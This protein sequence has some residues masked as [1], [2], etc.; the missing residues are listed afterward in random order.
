MF[1]ALTDPVAG[2]LGLSALVACVP[3]LTFFVM[4]IGVKAKA[5]I[6]AAVALVAALIVAVV[7]F[8]MPIGYALISATQGAAF[9]AFPIVYIILL[10]V[11]FYEVTVR[12]GRSEDLRRFFDKV[13]GGDIRIQ[14][15]LIAFSFGGL[16]EALAG[17]GAPIAITATMILALGVKPKRAA[18]A[19]MLANTAPVAYGAVAT[20][21]TTAGNMV[22]GGDASVASAT[23]QHVAAIVGYQAPLFALSV[24]LLLVI[25]LD[26]KRGARECW[27]PAMVVGGSFAITQWWCSNHFAYE[28]TDVV[29]ALVSMA[30][31]VAFM[32]FWKPRGVE[33]VRKDF[34]LPP[35][36]AEAASELNG[37]RI[38]MA[39][40]PY[41]VV[42]LV[43]GICKLGIPSLLSST[44]I[45][46]AWPVI[47]GGTILSAAGKDPGT[48]FTLNLLSTPGT[49]LLVAGMISALIY[50][51]FN[52]K[53]RYQMSMGAAV[54]ELGK[55]CYRMRFSALTIVLVLSL[56]Y[57]M[58]FSGQTIS[59]GEFLAG[60]GPAF[61]FISP[62]LGWVGT[63]VTGSDTSANALFSSLQYSAAQANPALA[64]VTPD[65][66]LAANTMGGVVG[67][68][69]SPQSLA[70]AAVATDER[71]ADIMKSVLPWS[72]GFLVV[73]CCLVF[74]QS[75]ILSFI[76]P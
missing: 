56:A 52:E 49:M 5:H 47:S 31:L 76:L 65:L 13:G 40:V 72:V 68:M 46:I 73:L 33:A 67:K 23:A 19:V 18:L 71:E 11:W 25:I 59:I 7:A 10:A 2:N 69:I 34:G 21:I 42:V 50:T 35:V 6:S 60:A 36:T 70:I 53:G 51:I 58:N 30:A 26:G 3:L 32:R 29:A 48:T 57:V 15:M 75:G 24:P 63:A 39:L 43:F 62:L 54:Q 74:L 64:N 4:L 38:F 28:L 12:S 8:Q 20:P 14:A 16:L 1:Q 44:D 66:F 37:T 55:T 61:A 9:G 17:F 45:K 41:I 22:A 27:I